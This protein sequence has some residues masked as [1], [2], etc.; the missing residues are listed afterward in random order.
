MWSIVGMVPETG[1]EPGEKG[2]A[3][4]HWSVSSHNGLF[5]GVGD[6]LLNAMTDLAES[7]ANYINVHLMR[8]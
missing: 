6:D 1:I 7:Q 5:S 8:H 4:S 2:S 3:Y